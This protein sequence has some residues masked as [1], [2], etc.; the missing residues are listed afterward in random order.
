[1]YVENI[2]AMYVLITTMQYLCKIFF[3]FLR[4]CYLIDLAEHTMHSH[5]DYVQ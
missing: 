5:M 1:M 3:S 2:E 4:S